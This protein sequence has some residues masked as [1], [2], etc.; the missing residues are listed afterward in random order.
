MGESYLPPEILM[1][2]LPVLV[3]AMS[4][5]LRDWTRGSEVF[6]KWGPD[7]ASCLCRAMLLA[8][9]LILA[10]IRVYIDCTSRM[11]SNARYSQPSPLGDFR[12]FP[13]RTNVETLQYA[14]A[15]AKH[16][17]GIEQ[18]ASLSRTP[19]TC[20]SFKRLQAIIHPPSDFHHIDRIPR[21]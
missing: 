8:I 6:A 17:P 21:N 11:V 10:W 2:G 12:D 1:M 15:E 13:R 16:R 7:L 14:A 20:E 3:M 18:A 19:S 5:R 9:W 4:W